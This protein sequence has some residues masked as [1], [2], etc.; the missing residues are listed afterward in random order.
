MCRARR[1]KRL[2]EFD[3]RWTSQLESL[4]SGEVHAVCT[5]FIHALLYGIFIVGLGGVLEG[6]AQAGCGHVCASEVILP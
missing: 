5:L 1:E 2:G 4:S 6:A 3:L